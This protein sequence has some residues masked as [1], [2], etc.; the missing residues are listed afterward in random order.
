MR[1]LKRLIISATLLVVAALSVSVSAGGW[2]VATLD[3][4]P[5][6]VTGQETT[7]GFTLRQHGNT[8]LGGVRPSQITFHNTESGQRLTFPAPDD[9]PHGHYAARFTLPQAGIWEW[10]ISNFGEH[11]MPS[12]TVTG[13][14]PAASAAST[15][16]SAIPRPLAY[17]GMVILTALAVLG[18]ALGYR[19]RGQP[20]ASLHSRGLSEQRG[21]A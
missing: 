15:A 2:A 4:M 18:F 8:L 13:A 3:T 19:W 6:F 7:V 16:G 20:S 17:P 21:A 11:P 5:T 1:T 14:T 10:S 9:G 12:L